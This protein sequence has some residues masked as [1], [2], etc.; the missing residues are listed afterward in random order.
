MAYNG[1]DSST[2]ANLN[3]EVSRARYKFPKP[4]GLNAALVEEAGEWAHEVLIAPLAR[5]NHRRELLQVAC[6][7]LRLYEE[8]DPLQNDPAMMVLMFEVS[9]LE[10]SAR[11]VL[12]KLCGP[13]AAA[14]S[15]P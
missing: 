4:D 3:Q 2:I 8:L 10:E 12:E 15:E 5:E 1:L 6:V 9:D 13:E 11:R 7:A 14:K